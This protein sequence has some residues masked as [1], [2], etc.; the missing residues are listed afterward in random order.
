MKIFLRLA[1]FHRRHI[2]NMGIIIKTLTVLTQK[3]KQSGQPI[4]FEW[5][6]R[7]QDFQIIK[8]ALISAPVLMSPDLG[9]VFLRNN[10][11][12]NEYRATL[13]QLSDENNHVV[14]QASRATNEAEEKCPP[15]KSEITAIVF[16][17]SESF[18]VHLFGHKITVLTDN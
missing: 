4:P 9:R 1:N 7:E 11:C 17:C 6:K 18:E 14:D 12:E 15:T 5:D 16:I 3:D 8:E 13:E 10:A 2:R